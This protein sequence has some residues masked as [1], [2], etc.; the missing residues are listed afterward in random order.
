[1]NQTL[2]VSCNR[3]KESALTN[4]HIHS[5]LPT[6]NAISFDK[7]TVR[8]HLSINKMKILLVKTIFIWFISQRNETLNL[9]F[10]DTHSYRRVALPVFC[11]K[12]TITPVNWLLNMTHFS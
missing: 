1:M 10:D 12:N 4:T 8:F 2:F 3:F 9:K 6:L 7:P 5:M 11:L